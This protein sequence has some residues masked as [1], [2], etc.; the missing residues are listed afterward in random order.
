MSMLN[1]TTPSNPL[2]NNEELC[3]TIQF[4]TYES[5]QL[6]LRIKDSSSSNRNSSK[7]N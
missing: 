6:Q 2:D 5:S 3:K 4:A 1:Y 7:I